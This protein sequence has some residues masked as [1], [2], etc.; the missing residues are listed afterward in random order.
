VRAPWTAASESIVV[1][2]RSSDL[3][4]HTSSCGSARRDALPRFPWLLFNQHNTMKGVDRRHEQGAVRVVS[5]RVGHFDLPPSS[6]SACRGAVSGSDRAYAS[7]RN[8]RTMVVASSCSTRPFSVVQASQ[9]GRRRRGTAQVFVRSTGQARCVWASWSCC[10][11]GTKLLLDD[12]VDRVV[13]RQHLPSDGVLALL[14]VLMTD[15]RHSSSAPIAVKYQLGE[16]TSQRSQ[17][18]C[19]S[20]HS[21]TL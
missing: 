3:R 15:D 2:R 18:S 8:T 17:F 9:G 5:C 21:M 13:D 20:L 6:V 10:S 7:A 4:P 11:T 12:V 14:R 16:A 19:A 1:N